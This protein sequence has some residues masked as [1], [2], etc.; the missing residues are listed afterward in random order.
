[1]GL[2]R[3]LLC[4]RAMW[5]RWIGC[6]LVAGC[7]SLPAYEEG[8]LA[9]DEGACPPSYRCEAD[10]RC[11][12]RGLPSP[13]SPDAPPVP[14]GVIDASPAIEE[15]PDATPPEEPD[16]TEFDAP[17]VEVPDAAPDAAA[18]DAPPA[19]PPDAAAP[20]PDAPLPVDAPPVPDAASLD[21]SVDACVPDTEARCEGKCGAVVNNCDETVDCGGT[22]GGVTCVGDEV[23]TDNACGCDP[24]TVRCALDQPQRCSPSGVW[25]DEGSACEHACLL[26]ACTVCEP[27]TATCDENTL[28]TCSAVGTL[29]MTP[30][31]GQACSMG[32]CT[33]VCTPGP[34]A[35]TCAD[36]TPST[37]SSMGTWVA[38][39]PCGE[40]ATCV[41]AVGCTGEC[42]AGRV[43]CASETSV[44]T[45]Q[46]DGT[47]STSSCG[48]GQV[49]TS[50]ACCTPESTSTTCSGVTTCSWRTNNCGQDVLCEGSCPA[51]Q[52]CGW[53]GCEDV[54]CDGDICGDDCCTGSAICC[55]CNDNLICTSVELC[56]RACEGP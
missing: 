18:I 23:C 17:V 42:R 46:G 55:F 28:V 11:Y 29:Q 4:A 7:V 36:N 38:G 50:G 24:G 32:A 44:R 35:I 25:Q 8:E 33:G 10:Q 31:T 49:C 51:G 34:T 1:L 54:T 45:C 3:R 5:L 40:S 9:C 12:R 43:E 15:P 39:A 53:S 16:A 13:G 21:A 6:L 47:W 27:N 41:N 2:A 19:S 30:C 26:G 48:G 22:S 20:P 37:C 14:V 52:V 56:N